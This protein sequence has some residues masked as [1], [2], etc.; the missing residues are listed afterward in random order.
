MLTNEILYSIYGFYSYLDQTKTYDLADMLGD[1]D[2][3]SI[4][5]TLTDKV[6]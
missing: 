3:L 5:M 4:Y 1:F 6:T 2:D